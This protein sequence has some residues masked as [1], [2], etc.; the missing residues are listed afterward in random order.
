M[1]KIVFSLMVL[2]FLTTAV[3]AQK[4]TDAAKAVTEKLTTVYS[5]TDTQVAEM[6]VIQERKYRNLSEIESLKDSDREKYILKLRAI[7]TGNDASIKKML[8]EE[9]RAIFD[10]RRVANR[11][12]MA[13][14][15]KQ[16]QSENLS[17]DAMDDRII[18]LEMEKLDNH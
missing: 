5:L 15:Y 17:K 18:A 2:C 10:Q 12:M 1:K 4:N 14:Q 8:T 16:M 13:V 9:Q 11:E 3:F 6:Q 7:Q